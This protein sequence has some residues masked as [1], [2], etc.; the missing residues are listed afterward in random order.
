MPIAVVMATAA[1]VDN[2]DFVV[3]KTI[4]VAMLVILVA[5]FGTVV[6]DKVITV[7]IYSLCNPIYFMYRL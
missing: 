7:Y 3:V 1:V 4:A 5:V 6:A 2:G